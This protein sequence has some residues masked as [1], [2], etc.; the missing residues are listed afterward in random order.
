M[1][2]NQSMLNKKMEEI[3]GSKQ[4]VGNLQNISMVTRIINTIHFKLGSFI[5]Y[6]ILN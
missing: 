3:L 5:F 6:S 2:K 1:E 4:L